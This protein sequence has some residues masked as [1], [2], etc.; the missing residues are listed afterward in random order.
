MKHFYVHDTWSEEYA[1]FEERKS[2]VKYASHLVKEWMKEMNENG[3]ADEFESDGDFRG[4]G[5]A[6]K[7][8]SCCDGKWWIKVEITEHPD[9][10]GVNKEKIF[11]VSDVE[12]E[13]LLDERYSK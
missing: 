12:L 11:S 5:Y 2:A 6:S 10:R 7:F 13:A 4:T 1:K 8:V 9:L 3:G